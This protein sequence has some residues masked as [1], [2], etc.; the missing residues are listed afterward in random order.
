MYKLELVLNPNAKNSY[1][2]KWLSLNYAPNYKGNSEGAKIFIFFES[3]PDEEVK[4]EIEVFYNAITIEESF[5]SLGDE[6]FKKHNRIQYGLILYDIVSSMI[7]LS[8]LQVDSSLTAHKSQRE[9][10]YDN[11]INLQNNIEHGNFISAYE[12]VET[13]TT[14]M[15]VT[16]EE[17]I[18]YRTVISTYLV[19]IQGE[20]IDAFGNKVN[21]GQYIELKGKSIDS[22]GFIIE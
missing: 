9:L 12:D 16:E 5:D 1:F 7:R 3:E 8:R 20:F 11:F 2:S 14:E 21:G 10:T 4:L 18:E 6:I 17:I 15:G 13:L 19:S 22:L